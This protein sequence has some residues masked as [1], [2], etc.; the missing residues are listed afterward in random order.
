M[1]RPQTHRFELDL[2]KKLFAH[3]TLR[4]A[5]SRQTRAGYIRSLLLADLNMFAALKNTKYP[6]EPSKNA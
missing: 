2:D 6:K 1:A 4:S 3:L 5:E